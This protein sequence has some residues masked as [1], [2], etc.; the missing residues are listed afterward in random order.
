MIHGAI[1]A[2]DY[3]GEL[4]VGI[5]YNSAVQHPVFNNFDLLDIENLE[6]KLELYVN[7]DFQEITAGFFQNSKGS[8]VMSIKDLSVDYSI[9]SEAGITIPE[10]SRLNHYFGISWEV[11]AAERWF[12]SFSLLLH[13]SM[14]NYR[15]IRNMEL[16]SWFHF[17]VFYD[18]SEFLTYFL[19]SKVGYYKNFDQALDIVNGPAVGLEL[20]LYIYPLKD[21]SFIKVTV[22]A[23]Y[24]NFNDGKYDLF[25]ER[26]SN[27]AAATAFIP[28]RYITPF[29]LVDQSWKAGKFTFALG[30][31]Y[32]FIHQFEESLMDFSQVAPLKKEHRQ[33][34]N[35]QVSPMIEYDILSF[36]GIKIFYNFTKNF[37]NLNREPGEYADL[38]YMIH[39]AGL[40][41][42]FHFDTS[43][44]K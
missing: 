36:L 22:G 23:D 17:D 2:E 20:G 18:K 33:D 12:L 27:N 29:L 19:S 40:E 7:N 30:G 16:D 41:L 28:G 43:K 39:S 8:I 21:M 1:F 26:D 32:L 5:S 38:N 11:V 37:S 44:K 42:Y 13:N 34:H 31:K 6:E 25:S 9:L 14:L 15:S 3:K 10:Y 4:S 24:F 35:I